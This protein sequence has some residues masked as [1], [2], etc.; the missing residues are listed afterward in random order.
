LIEDP[1][2]D[3]GLGIQQSIAD[4]LVD[5]VVRKEPSQIRRLEWDELIL[6]VLEDSLGIEDMEEVAGEVS[7]PMQ[8]DWQDLDWV[9]ADWVVD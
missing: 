1:I 5:G 9:E 6:Q 4:L 7:E 3:D 8:V 2:T